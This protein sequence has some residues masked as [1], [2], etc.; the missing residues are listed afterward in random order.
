MPVHVRIII[1]SCLTFKNILDD[2]SDQTIVREYI[3]EI[4]HKIF[5]LGS[6]SDKFI[7]IEVNWIL[8]YIKV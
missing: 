8:K 6:M 5:E 7:G 1:L 2:I 3:K 4:Y